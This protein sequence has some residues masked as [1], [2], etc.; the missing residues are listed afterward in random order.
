MSVKILGGELKGLPLKVLDVNSLRPTS[1]MLRRKFFDSFQDW[2]EIVFCDFFAGSGAMAFEALSRGADQIILNDKNKKVVEQL[3]LT[4]QELL[5]R[6]NLLS[7]QIVISNIDAVKRFKNFL[8]QLN[9]QTTYCFFIDPPYD[10]R[11]AY[12]QFIELFKGLAGSGE[13]FIVIEGDKT[14]QLP[15]DAWQEFWPESKLLWHGDHFLFMTWI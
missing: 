3:E 8:E 6:S 12:E 9:P 10:H 13:Q 5:Q 2:S 11:K 7:D 15:L 4:K 1:V 14:R